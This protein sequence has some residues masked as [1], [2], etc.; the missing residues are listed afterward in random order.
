VAKHKRRRRGA[1]NKALVL[2]LCRG[3]EEVEENNMLI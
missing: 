1:R 3:K 2:L